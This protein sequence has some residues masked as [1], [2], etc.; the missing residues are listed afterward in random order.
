M[1]GWGK[2]RL[3]VALLGLVAR[4]KMN[5]RLCLAPYPGFSASE[6]KYLGALTQPHINHYG[7]GLVLVPAL[8]SLAHHSKFVDMQPRSR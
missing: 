1:D 6:R 3:L 2:V 7:S 5:P 8:A 4:Y